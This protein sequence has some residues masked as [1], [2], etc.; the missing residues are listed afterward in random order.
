[1]DCGYGSSAEA[2]RLLAES[3]VFCRQVNCTRGQH[4]LTR[5]LV[6]SQIWASELRLGALIR[7]NSDLGKRAKCLESAWGLA[8]D[9]L[10]Q[11]KDWR[12][13]AARVPQTRKHPVQA[14][15][16]LALHTARHHRA[17]Q[18][19]QG[20]EEE[21]MR[22][23][24]EEASEG[25]SNSS[26]SSRSHRELHDDLNL[27]VKRNLPQ[28][29]Q[30]AT[31]QSR[32]AARRGEG[33]QS[34]QEDEEEK[35]EV[36]SRGAAPPARSLVQ[37]NG[38]DNRQ[39]R[40]VVTLRS[41]LR[42]VRNARLC[43]GVLL[44]CGEDS[45][46]KAWDVAPLQQHGMRL[47]GTGHLEDLEPFA[48]YRGHA[49]AVLSLA[50]PVGPLNGDPAG[51]LFFS[52]GLDGEICAWRLLMPAEHDPYDATPPNASGH[53][54]HGVACLQ[55]FKGHTDAVWSLS[56]QDE[57]RL[58]A[59]AGADELVLLWKAAA[60]ASLGP[61]VTPLEPPLA[62]SAEAVPVLLDSIG[63]DARKLEWES[64]GTRDAGDR[65]HRPVSA[66]FSDRALMVLR[67]LRLPPP[68]PGSRQAE[69]RTLA[70]ACPPSF[71]L[72]PA[73][74]ATAF[75]PRVPASPASSASRRAS[76][77]PQPS[78]VPPIIRRLGPGGQ[79]VFEFNFSASLSH[80]MSK[81]TGVVAGAAAVIGGAAFVGLPTTQTAA[82]RDNQLLA[83]RGAPRVSSAAGATSTSSTVGL[84]VAG[85]AALALSGRHAAAS[86]AAPSAGSRRVAACAYDASKEIGVCD[87]LL[88]WDPIGFCE[89]GTKEEFDRRR[90]VELKHGRLCMFATIGLVWPDLFGKWG[91]YLSP[92]QGLKF[93]DVPSGIAAISKVPI[94]GWAQILLVAG[95][96]ETQLFKDQSI[97]GPGFAKYGAEP[98]NF[99]TG[100]LGRKIKDPAERRLK[101]T[102]EL[103]NGRLA[104]IATLAMLVQNGLTGQSP[105][106]QLTSGH[107]SPFNDGQGYFAQ[108]DPSKEL[109]ACPPLGYW[110]PFGMM[111]F[112]DET[113]FKKNREAEL[114]HGRVCMAAAIGVN[115]SFEFPFARNLPYDCLKHL[116]LTSTFEASSRLDVEGTQAVRAM[117]LEFIVSHFQTVCR[118]PALEQ[119]DKPL[120]IE[121][122]RGLAERFPQPQSPNL[123]PNAQPGCA[124]SG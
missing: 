67:L 57:L 119:L 27:T 31:T 6:Q 3:E 39:W 78:A 46:V 42:G 103:N 66:E 8:Q 52:G 83:L 99:G 20:E 47:P 80:V 32:P 112:Q 71:A 82:S 97:G 118:Q 92:S 87:P 69:A 61:Q 17:T 105:I 23:S 28:L 36:S 90:A 100:Y 18:E 29:S 37:E 108:F 38:A 65:G 1:M 56:L 34:E 25:N 109:G 77:S 106:E 91:G 116:N 40:R 30:G 68:V 115:D 113:T 70:H 88:F 110:D 54:L 76:P 74:P 72:P 104:M 102:T 16:R 75:P 59:S 26:S 117:A 11:D 50:A 44:T 13:L 89:G 122:L 107:I 60:E 53:R 45:L 81:S 48:T 24:E 43:G 86:A 64:P 9:V 73:G 7:Q 95:L 121:I 51:Q 79:L 94:E 85:L 49:G 98:G 41:H 14:E 124:P 22:R 35:A 19:E 33:G 101:L 4:A 5:E 111:A 12:Q 10:S 63:S 123:S 55:Q 15:L 93:T 21:E 96:I 84:G 58:L 2:E 120:L 114:K 62:S